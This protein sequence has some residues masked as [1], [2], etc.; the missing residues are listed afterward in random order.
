MIFASTAR[1]EQLS[2]PLESAKFP[3]RIYPMGQVGRLWRERYMEKIT[4]FNG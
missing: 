3:I 2:Y 1:S 4:I